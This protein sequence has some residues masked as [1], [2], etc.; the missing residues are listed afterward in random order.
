MTSGILYELDMRLRPSGN[1]GVLVVHIETFADYQQQEAWTWEHQALVRARAIY[2]HDEIIKQFN[3]IRQHVLSKKRESVQLEK[4]VTEMRRKMLQHLNKSTAELLDIKQSKGGLVDIE[5]LAQYL[6]LAHYSQHSSQLL[7]SDN[8]RLFEQLAQWQVISEDEKSKLIT[9]YCQLRDFGH[10][11]VLQNKAN[12]MPVHDF[13]LHANEVI[14]I[15]DKYL[16]LH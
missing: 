11:C 4:D 7:P 2:G 3:G 12:L 14:E 1:S 16:A 6:V 5:F 13:N 9:H 10:S 15:V 8:I